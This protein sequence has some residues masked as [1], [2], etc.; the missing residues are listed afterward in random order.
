MLKITNQIFIIAVILLMVGCKSTEQAQ[1]DTAQKISNEE[2]SDNSSVFIEANKAKI[3]GNVEEARKLF[4]QCLTINPQDAA[5]MF[6]LAKIHINRKEFDVASHY[7]DQATQIEPNNVYY[8]ML[9]ASLL[10]AQEN[11]KA[12]IKIYA[13]ILELKPGFPEYYDNL[14]LAYLY[15]DQPDEALRVYSELEEKAG[16]SEDL[17]M[18]KHGIYLQEG[19][20]DKAAAE[21]Q[22]L[23]EAFPNESKYYSILAELYVSEGMNEEAL[24]AYQKVKEIDPDNPYIDISLADF[25][26]KQGENKK[27]FEHLKAGFLNKNLDID[28]KIQVLIRYYTANEI[29]SDLKEEAFELSEALVETHPSNPKAY[30][31]YGD[32]LYQDEQ[33]E[34][35]R[36]AFKKVIELDNSKYIVWEQLLFTEAELQNNDSLLTESQKAIE[37]FPEQPLPY[38]FAGSVHYQQKNWEQAVIILEQGLFYVVNNDPLMA[39]FYAYLG[40]SYYQLKNIE[41]SDEAYDNALKIDPNNDYV[42]NNYAYYL[43]LR[44][45]NL[46]RAAQ[47]AKKATEIKPSSSNMDTYGWVLFKLGYYEEALI[48]IEKALEDGALDNAVI[49][50]HYGDVLWKLNRT[51]EAI[52]K[53][54]QAQEAGEGSDLLDKKVREKNYF[55]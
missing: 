50:E 33:Y 25:Y 3:L 31:M 2:F 55:E 49:L 19:K 41:K 46:E 9:Y 27:A 35:A 44:G 48:W 21:I 12:S 7:L 6:E 53:W 22:K 17:I 43:S 36:D 15:N 24:A 54:Q 13:R 38:L 34:K 40:D 10:Q 18:K 37:L 39:Q 47:M 5:S 20:V 29:Y 16:I 32:F 42:L 11:Y 26:K 51:E 52:H 28:S 45:E 23:I 4:E 1:K 8:L 30:S 14:A